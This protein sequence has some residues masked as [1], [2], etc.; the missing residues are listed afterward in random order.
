MI[1]ILASANLT[2]MIVA[3][4]AMAIACALLSVFVVLRHWSLVGEGI[5][6]S[7]FGGAGTAWLLA[8]YFPSFDNPALVYAAVVVFCLITAI[9]IGWLSRDQRVFPDAAVGIFIVASLAWGLLAQQIYQT[10]RHAS[11]ADFGNLLFGQITQFSLG[12]TVA[13]VCVSGLIILTLWLLNKE[14]VSYTFD[15]MAA[16]IS[17]INATLIHYILVL[18]IAAVVIISVRVVGTVLATALLVLPGT[19]ALLLSKNLRSVLIY[20]IATSVIAV[21]I[22]L[23]IYMRWPS[24][25]LGPAIVLAL[26]IEFTA[27]FVSTK[28]RKPLAA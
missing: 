18:L 28:L 3:D 2:N 12:Y 25:P 9:A 1:S 7:G 23:L 20:S 17:G 6:H 21:V 10:E 26:V 4:L 14:I 27:V 22:G 16:R 5:S 24:L 19:T 15:P 8:A 13:V 11:P